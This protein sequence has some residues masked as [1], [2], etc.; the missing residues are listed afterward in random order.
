MMVM[1]MSMMMMLTM[2][3]DDD[4]NDVDMADNVDTLLM[5]EIKAL[6]I[7]ASVFPFSGIANKLKCLCP[8]KVPT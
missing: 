6:L 4:D 1:M 5:L 8:D 2:N 7:A 3:D